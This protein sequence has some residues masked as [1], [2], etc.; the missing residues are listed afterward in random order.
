MIATTMPCFARFERSSPA[1]WLD[2]GLALLA[3]PA[4]LGRE[5]LRRAVAMGTS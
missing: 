5:V 1:W 2:A 4:L 3:F